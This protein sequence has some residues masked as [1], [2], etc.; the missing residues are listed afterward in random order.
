MA[1]QD[2]RKGLNED[3]ELVTSYDLIAAAHE[4]MGGIDLDVASSKFANNHVQADHYYTPSDD[5]LNAQEWF[6]NVYLF[7]PAGAYFWDKKHD[8]WKK[9]RASSPSL[10]SSHAVWFRKLYR[11]WLRNEIKQGL[12]FTNCPDM[13]RYDQRIFDFPMCI[14]RT[15]PVLI[16]NTSKGVFQHRTCTSLV[17]YLQPQDDPSGATEKF[18]KIYAPKGR[19]LV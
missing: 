1:I 14:L 7:P 8:R 15:A 17:V 6:G 13:I 16:K 5:G 18:S 2:I 10:V 3:I 19:I 12:Y 11:L 4:L 9:T